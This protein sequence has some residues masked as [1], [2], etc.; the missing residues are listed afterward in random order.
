MLT[1]FILPKFINI[2]IETFTLIR[3]SSL[4]INQ[5]TKLSPIST[6]RPPLAMEPAEVFVSC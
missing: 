2:Y 5:V 6:E 4:I 3:G 1:R